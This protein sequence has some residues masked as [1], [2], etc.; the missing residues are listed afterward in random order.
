M[1]HLREKE[2]SVLEEVV[3]AYIREASPISSRH[4]VESGSFSSSPATI[5][6]IMMDLEEKGF[7]FQPHTSAGRVPTQKAYRFFVDTCVDMERMS[8][9]SL[10]RLFGELD[11]RAERV[12]VI[13]QKAH[14][15]AAVLDEEDEI[16]YFGAEELFSEPEFAHDP[17]LVRSFGSL[18]DSLYDILR[19]YHEATRHTPLPRVFIERENPAPEARRMSVIASALEDDHG[20][21]IA[22]G[23]SRMNYE[24]V[25]PMLRSL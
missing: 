2:Q 17:R 14:V 21:V 23:P 6:N 1:M 19:E 18:I 10:M 20:V 22:L 15:F 25:I 7:L 24:I 16:T 13:T 11:L 12:R 3:R 5:R 9:G 8:P 4:V